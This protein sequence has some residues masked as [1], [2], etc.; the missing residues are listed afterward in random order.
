[1]LHEGAHSLDPIPSLMV[2]THWQVWLRY[3]ALLEIQPKT[4]L[5]RKICP[6]V[7]C[8][9]FTTGPKYMQWHRVMSTKP[10]FAAGSTGVSVL[11]DAL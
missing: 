3:L 2:G 1:M 6:L 5:E 10:E 9:W 11:S 8:L 7:K 4:H